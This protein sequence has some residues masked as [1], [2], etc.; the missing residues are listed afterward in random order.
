MTDP[1]GHQMYLYR[2]NVKIFIFVSY[3]IRF[4]CIYVHRYIYVKNVEIKLLDIV[5]QKN[6]AKFVKLL[7]DRAITKYR[8]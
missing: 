5:Y 2:A 1:N 4:N 6:V 8:D 7:I 3:Q